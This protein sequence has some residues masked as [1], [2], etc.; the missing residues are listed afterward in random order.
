MPDEL[1]NCNRIMTQHAWISLIG[2]TMGLLILPALILSIIYV[3][4]WCIFI[5]VGLLGSIILAI[6]LSW[7]RIKK[8][9][10]QKPYRIKLPTGDLSQFVDMLNLS[11][12]DCV[13]SY[14]FTA[15]R[16]FT[17]R[18][19]SIAN[20][21]FDK[22][23]IDLRRKKANAEINRKFGYDAAGGIF[24]FTNTVRI[25]LVIVSNENKELLSWINRDPVSLL[26]RGEAIVN[27]AIL[28]ENKTLVFPYLLA[29]LTLGE[30]Q[31]YIAVASFLCEKLCIE[32]SFVCKE[33]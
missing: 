10:K 14:G 32:N 22:A 29:P 26:A 18:I 33:D 2:V 11:P 28:L 8:H 31:R 19:L 1:R 24:G 27:A 25:N 23:V 5:T 30:A 4:L 7:R 15:Y 17:L 12:L 3:H 20:D 21:Y 16:G 13:C 9:P 6:W